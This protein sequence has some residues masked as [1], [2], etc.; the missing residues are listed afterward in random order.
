MNFNGNSSG[1]GSS[2]G[3]N[4]NEHKETFSSGVATE[5]FTYRPDQSRM[6]QPIA[7]DDEIVFESDEM[8]AAVADPDVKL[9]KKRRRKKT[10]GIL[11][12]VFFV[13][14]IS[15]A[16]A[17]Y[18]IR[19]SMKVEMVV[20]DKRTNTATRNEAASSGNNLTQQAIKEMRDVTRNAPATTP[21]SGVETVSV[22]PAREDTPTTPGE[23]RAQTPDAPVV[24]EGL[25]GTIKAPPASEQTALEQTT[26]AGHTKT[27]RETDT[28][29]RPGEV[30]QTRNR[31]GQTSRQGRASHAA[32]PPLT[33]GT[34]DHSI[35]I[36]ESTPESRSE[37]ARVRASGVMP[38][39]AT[40]RSGAA[41]EAA[42]ET[43]TRVAMPSFG[44]MLPVRT[45]GAIYTLR[46]GALTR[47]EVTRD[48]SGEGWKLPRGTVFVGTLRGG[49][50][51]RAY[52]AMIGF[53]DPQTGRL[54]KVGGDVLG[55]D[56][57][58]GLKGKRRRL[59]SR[60]GRVVG[61]VGRGAVGLAQSALSGRN[62]GMTII[63]PGINSS[64]SPEL[65]G[66]SGK[67]NNREF[68]EVEAGAPAYVMITDL[69]ETIKGVDA[70]ASLNGDELAGVFGSSNQGSTSSLT[71][72][73]LAALLSSGSP[74]QIR[75]AMPKMS[76]NMRQIA[77]AVLEQSE[78]Q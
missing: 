63:M 49:E 58:S 24:P 66:L 56:G 46:S 48:V 73:E 32:N 25:A 22:A 39:A 3:H 43:E 8:T 16:A 69:P 21:S 38:R 9:R 18:L 51:D 59:S 67:G 70:L 10:I 50:Y 14:G 17:F 27:A 71:D 53:I 28:E 55:A 60:W 68:V 40:E 19:R 2:N 76:M 72:A 65:S 45:L 54:V 64:V 62:G 5:T 7:S 57:A 30:A 44:T 15:G 31:S 6:G 1:N 78:R 11:L 12:I 26:T 47:F 4:G 35:Y 29:T 77:Q 20:G 36:T 42:R 37:T 33:N 13:L 34:V 75:E 74:E 61:E 41:R 23:R 52:M